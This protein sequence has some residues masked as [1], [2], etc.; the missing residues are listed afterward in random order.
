MTYSTPASE[1]TRPTRAGDSP[2]NRGQWLAVVAIVITV[3]L[4]A[5]SFS[6]IRVTGEHLSAGPMA[7]LRVS[8]AGLVLLPFA[9]RGR[10]SAA[11]LPRDRSAWAVLAYGALWF[12]GYFVALNQTERYVDAATAALL[13]NLSPLLIAVGAVVFLKEDASPLLVAGTLISLAGV[14]VMGYGARD[15][16]ARI[17]PIGILLGV[18]AASVYATAV[19]FQ[20]RLLGTMNIFHV[21]WLGCATGTVLLLPFLPALV[22]ELQTSPPEV[23]IGGV[24][25][26]LFPTALGFSTW[27]YALQRSPASRLGSVGYLVTV[28]SV[29]MSWIFLSEIPTFVVLTGG[30]VCFAGVVLARRTP[31]PPPPDDGGTSALVEPALRDAVR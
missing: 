9:L 8:I 14:A 22:R 15:P 23:V 11:L 27:A 5:S 21:T 30:V 1:Q 28:T 12:A 31:P 4:W 17:E 16:D 2:V 25:L 19:L 20:K 13:I 3:L 18:A 10:G 29:F 7:L 26:G 24:Y 6:V